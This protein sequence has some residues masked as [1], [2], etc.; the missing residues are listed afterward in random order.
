MTMQKKII[1]TILKSDTMKVYVYIYIY[2][3]ICVCI[4]IYNVYTYD[5]DFFMQS[6]QEI[7]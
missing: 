3:H 7:G 2:T 6:D 5:H 1:T 4:N